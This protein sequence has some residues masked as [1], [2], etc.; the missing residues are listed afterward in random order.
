MRKFKINLQ[1]ALVIYAPG[2]DIETYWI[3]FREV[4]YFCYMYAFTNKGT[5]RFF[6]YKNNIT[7]KK[8]INFM[9]RLRAGTPGKTVIVF[10]NNEVRV[11]KTFNAWINKN[12]NKVDI[13]I[14]RYTQTPALLNERRSNV[15][16]NGATYAEQYYKWD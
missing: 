13:L 9:Y 11:G 4:G 5:V 10:D 8:I 15:Y 14:L 3:R 16:F 12:Q 2:A 1:K 7:Q 6:V